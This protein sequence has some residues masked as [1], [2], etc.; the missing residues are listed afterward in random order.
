MKDKWIYVN[1][2]TKTIFLRFRVKGF[3]KQF[4]LS[5]GLVDNKTNRGIIIAR[6]E[7]IER[8]IALSRFDSSLASYRFGQIKASEKMTLT[9]I[10]NKF[11]EFQAEHLEKSTLLG[12]YTTFSVILSKIPSNNP[13][14]AAI[15]RDFLL[16]KY[17]YGTT[18]RLIESLY[19][20]YN[21]AIKSKLITSNP[22]TEIRLIRPKRKSHNDN[23]K[24]YTLSERDIIINAFEKHEK[25]SHYAP[26]I[27]FLFYTGCRPGEAFSITWADISADCTQITISKAYAS[28]ANVTKGTKNNKRRIFVC[29]HD[30]K[31]QKMLLNLKDKS[32]SSNL[33]FKSINGLQMRIN[34][35]GRYWR[36]DSHKDGIVRELA[37]SGEIPYL[38]IYSTRHTFATW[39]IASGASPEKVAYW[40]GDN[41]QTVLTYYCHPDVT[42]TICPD[43]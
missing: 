43:F 8:D 28:H 31:L 7:I 27:K 24:A 18:Y 1:P 35:L 13:N 40:I 3:P 16:S 4:Y 5:T 10:W 30:S 38:N 2:K 36:G 23:N 39:A 21:W 17:S 15:I 25:F 41:V 29:G 26:L 33:V 11:L 34:I 19:R 14:D 9:E 12:D 22:F 37:K 6:I 42:R 20:C 32:D